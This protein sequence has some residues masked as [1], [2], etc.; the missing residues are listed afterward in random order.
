MDFIVF[1][2]WGNKVFESQKLDY[3]W[4]GTYKGQAMNTGTY[5][6]YVKATMLDGTSVEKQGNVAL[7][8]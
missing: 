5:A 7:I 4:D 1:D 2:R 6:W 3:G 8:R